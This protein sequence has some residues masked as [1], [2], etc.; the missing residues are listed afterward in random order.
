MWR[1]GTFWILSTW[2]YRSSN[3]DPEDKEHT[4]ILPFTNCKLPTSPGPSRFQKSIFHLLRTQ[5]EEWTIDITIPWRKWSFLL[6]NCPG[7][8]AQPSKCLKSRP[9]PSLVFQES[10]IMSTFT[11]QINLWME[12]ILPPLPNE[13]ILVLSCFLPSSSSQEPHLW[14]QEELK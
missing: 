8:A 3:A 5:E 2:N 10:V 6:A 13:N 4:P 12:N 1:R 9:V 11:R 14:H 7:N